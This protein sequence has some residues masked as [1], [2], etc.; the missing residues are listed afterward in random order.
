LREGEHPKPEAAAMS[1]EHAPKRDRTNRLAIP[2]ADYEALSV[3]EFCE[4]H[5]VSRSLLY[6]LW[7][8][9]QGPKF[10][11]AGARRLISKEAAAA[12]RREREAAS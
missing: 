11:K 3:V 7:A 6:K 9:G 4:I 10:F 1:L 2:H 12:W 8:A 5:G